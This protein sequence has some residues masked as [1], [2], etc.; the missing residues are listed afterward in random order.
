MGHSPRGRDEIDFYYCSNIYL[1]NHIFLNVVCI[2]SLTL[3]EAFFRNVQN[4]IID[5]MFVNML[6]T[7]NFSLCYKRELKG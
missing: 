3:I 1:Q 6:F 4:N 7:L 2:S 5:I